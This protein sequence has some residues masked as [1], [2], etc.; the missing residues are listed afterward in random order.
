M[1]RQYV[2]ILTIL[3]SVSAILLSC[4][5]KVRDN[6][7]GS[8]A[9]D[10][11]SV[12]KTE[13]LFGDTA[14]PMCSLVINVTYPVKSSDEILTDSLTYHIINTCFGDRYAGLSVT[15]AINQ[16]AKDYV[17]DYRAD[18]EPLY[19]EEKR[20][21]AGSD[22]T[23]GWYSYY[24]SIDGKVQYYENSL[25]IYKF[26]YEEYTG[27][28]HGMHATFYTN[29]DLETKQPLTLDD[30]LTGDYKEAVTDLIWNQLMIDNKAGSHEE[31]EDMG[32]GSTGEIVPTDNFF[33]DKSGI[34]FF[35]NVYEITPYAMGTTKV[36]ISFDMLE[37]WLS[38]SRIIKD[39]R[40]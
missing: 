9:F 27:G 25:L 20:D 18:I 13:H 17:A 12:E 30:I 5:N 33:L 34:T 7:V 40:N 36:N 10:S 28:A 23:S 16:Y 21:S 3:I 26:S 15:E 14:A 1:R 6:K 31:L 39:L 19:E 8:I 35:Y 24:K 38:N 2:S 32:Y 11:I 4:G 29:I 22:I 37:N